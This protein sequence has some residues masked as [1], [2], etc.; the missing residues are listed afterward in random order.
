LCSPC[1]PRC[2]A[3]NL[4]AIFTRMD[5]NINGNTAS[6]DNDPPKHDFILHGC[7]LTPEGFVVYVR[8]RSAQLNIYVQTEDFHN[9]PGALRMLWSSRAK[10]DSEHDEPELW[11]YHEQIASYFLSALRE[12]V[13]D[14]NYV[15]RLTLADLQLKQHYQCR[16][17][18]YDEEPRPSAIIEAE[19]QEEDEDDCDYFGPATA[20]WPFPR[21]QAS[22]VE[23]CYDDPTTIFEIVPEK[24]FV[25]GK[26]FFWK[27]SWISDE[28]RQ[29]VEKYCRIHGSSRSPQ[30]LLTSR[31]Y[32]IVVDK[33]GFLRGQLYH[34]IE[35]GHHLTWDVL[36]TTPIATRTK[37]A[38]Q[39]RETLATLH[40]MDVIWG[41][42]KA[43]NVLIDK[44]GNAIVIDLE[45][46]ATR[47]WID[48]DKMGT[49]EGDLQGLERL[50]DYI[51]N[52]ECTLRIRDKE[53]DQDWDRE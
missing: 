32:G 41:D 18:F 23:V 33:K 22:D 20:T 7:G 53:L 50:A 10:I 24:V 48:E 19:S 12:V 17:E 15:G 16:L 3:L 36:E 52:D 45:G 38:S 4:F 44:L 34:W 9:S 35:V 30:E 31:L 27:P 29:G 47:G 5:I 51:L 11:E 1:S 8:L 37:W 46:G 6:N 21:F 28:S 14:V 2:N 25:H 40:A 49:R 39:V 42:V 43:E 13:P 26:A